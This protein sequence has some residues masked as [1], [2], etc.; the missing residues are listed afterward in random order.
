MMGV[1]NAVGLAAAAA[2]YLAT[3][4]DAHGWVQVPLAR[5]L[6]N[7][8]EVKWATTVSAG[9][10]A[11]DMRPPYGGVPGLCGDPFGSYLD[12]PPSNFKAMP[13]EIQETYQEGG[14]IKAQVD[15]SANHG[16]FFELSVCDSME[17]TQECFDRNKLRT[18]EKDSEQWH[19]MTRT[20]DDPSPQRPESYFMDWKLPEGLS[21]EH[22]VVQWSW[23]TAHNCLY[24]C[25]KEV[26][27]FY[28][29]LR[30]YV[31]RPDAEWDMKYCETK[32]PVKGQQPQMFRNCADIK[33]EPKAG[34]FALTTPPPNG[35]MPDMNQT[36]QDNNTQGD[37]IFQEESECRTMSRRFLLD[38]GE[39]EEEDSV[40]D[41]SGAGDAM[42]CG[43]YMVDQV[44][45]EINNMR[46]EVHAQ[47][48]ECSNRAV[49]VSENFSEIM[50]EQGRELHGSSDNC[51]L[52]K[53][54]GRCAQMVAVGTPES[55]ALSLGGIDHAMLV[56]PE[57]AVA[58]VGYFAFEG[59]T[60]WTIL[61][62]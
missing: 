25:E 57:Y 2:V 52:A 29:D 62:G 20:I 50:S 22:C 59:I 24:P 14:I 51:R 30:N 3:S 6:C 54:T 47:P 7:G 45:I 26:C 44:L 60:Y 31:V 1:I 18:V 9:S 41:V 5:Q 42:N 32:Y 27:G 56:A 58:G 8:D 23:W 28:A 36:Q 35:T 55:P 13:C 10:G 4:V 33:I 46:K 34:G 11:R 17:I 38:I 48:L 15:I 40:D 37:E 53:F 21:C 19:I 16:G 12:N 61:L 39:L 43:D 49:G